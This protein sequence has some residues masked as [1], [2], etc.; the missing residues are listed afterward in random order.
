VA[1]SAGVFTK[2]QINNKLEMIVK[3]RT[4][5]VDMNEVMVAAP[6][7]QAQKWGYCNYKYII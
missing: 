3:G 1:I 7:C 5:E 6:H 4:A 2:E